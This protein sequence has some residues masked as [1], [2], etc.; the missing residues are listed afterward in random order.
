MNRD[1]TNLWAYRRVPRTASWQK[2]GLAVL[3]TAGFVSLVYLFDWWFRAAHVHSVPW[4]VV[5][6]LIFWWGLIRM[7]VLWISYLRIS[8]PRPVAAQAGLRVAIFTTSSPGEPLGMFEKT[9]AACARIRYPHTTYLLDDTG[10]PRYREVAERYGA[11]WL[12]LTGLPGAKAGKINAALRQTTE[13]FVLVLDPD[14][15]PFP[16]FLD[17]VLGYFD[18][19]RVGFVQVAQAYYNQERSF[20][21]R[22]AAEQTYG[23][24]GPTQMGMYGHSCAVA[25]GANCTFR[26][27]ALKSIGGHGIGLAEDLVT[28]IRLH[29]AGWTSVYVPSIVSR[30]LVPED[31]GSFCKQQLK[32]ARGVHEV[33]FAELPRLWPR[34]SG[35][36]RLSYLTIGTYYFSGVITLLFLLIPYL[37][38]WFR[39]LPAS[40]DFS[41][42][43]ANW[44][45][46]AVTGFSIYLYVQQWLC[47]PSTERG[48]HWR[49]MLL[50]FACW[51]VFFRGFVLALRN[52]D[53]PY[54]PTAKQAVKGFTHFVRPLLVQQL[55]FAGT[56]VGIGIKR[57][58]YTAE[59]SLSLTS[60]EVWGMVLFAAIACLASFGGVYAAW[61]STRP[62]PGDPWDTV[63]PA[64]IDVS[65]RPSE[66]LRD[67]PESLVTH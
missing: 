62:A 2:L 51:P 23:F 8:Q 37:F 66:N 40:M 57:G 5:L 20:T 30:G 25:I 17:E 31:L 46:V 38:L 41:E 6:S 61:Q 27:A 11:F 34:L 53:I 49:G 48:L 13:E 26:R 52:A 4:F 3:V 55:I 7:A 60:G 58:F 50:K 12:E 28:A 63:N 15:I 10:D 39:V 19:P 9:L 14:H 44:L 64:G 45:P 1:Q 18:N 22:G 24:Y 16:N 56:L 42:F 35:W 47:H 21:A 33:L 43:L 65:A 29:A 54:I 36:Q 67:Q 32:W 59:A